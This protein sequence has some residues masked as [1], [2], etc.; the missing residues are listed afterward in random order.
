MTPQKPPT[1]LS[2]REV[3][4]ALARVGLEFDRQRGSRM[5]LDAEGPHVVIFVPDHKSVRV[6]ALRN[7]IRDARLPVAEF[8]QPV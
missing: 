6:R 4:K 5:V 7:V 2:G 8:R 3:R 1:G